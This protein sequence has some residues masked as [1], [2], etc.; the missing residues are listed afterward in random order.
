[1][2]KVCS[3]S[4]QIYAPRPLLWP[5]VLVFI[6]IFPFPWDRSHFGGVLV[7]VGATYTL[8]HCFGWVP[9]KDVSKEA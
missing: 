2:S 9:A 3:Q 7:P 4:N 6:V 8:A 1:M 5:V